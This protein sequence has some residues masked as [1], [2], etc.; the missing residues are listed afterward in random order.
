[1]SPEN[2]QKIREA[3]ALGG[4]ALDGNLPPHPEHSSRNPYAHIWHSVKEKMG[5]SYKECGDDQ[6]EEILDHISYLVNNPK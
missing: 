3:V 6:V 2:M 1:M 5:Q 4:K